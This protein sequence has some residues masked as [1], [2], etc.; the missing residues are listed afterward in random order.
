MALR[1]PDTYKLGFKNFFSLSLSDKNILF[2]KIAALEEDIPTKKVPEYLSQYLTLEE[3]EIR[4]IIDMFLSLFQ[5]KEGSSESLDEFI[6][7]LEAALNR[8]EEKELEAPTTFKDDLKRLF[9]LN[10][11]YSR[12]KGSY[13]SS[14]REKLLIDSRILTDIRPIF[15][16][17]ASC[18]LN[19]MIVVHNLK[20][21]YKHG[22]DNKEAFFA[23]DLEDLE[24]LKSQIER[25]LLKEKNLKA[26]L[27]KADFK[28]IS[29]G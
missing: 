3:E 6:S 2:N 11:F 13:L 17:D 27:Q 9:S 29:L 23:L 10:L 24:R 8:L 21:E 15:T 26:S 16:D 25:A 28:I 1:I 18:I 5:A 12:V 20:L 4:E 19:G 7:D 22:I 14:E